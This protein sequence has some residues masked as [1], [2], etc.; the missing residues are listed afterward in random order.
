MGLFY[1]IHCKRG[2]TVG[3]LQRILL[4]HPD[5]MNWGNHLNVHSHA[6]FVSTLQNA[7]F[8]ELVFGIDR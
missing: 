1:Q 5:I 3:L 4:T 6:P 7:R 2:A 8:H